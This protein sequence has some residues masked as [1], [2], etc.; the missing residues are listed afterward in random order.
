MTAATWQHAPLTWD[1][2]SDVVVVGSGFAG[3]AAA[4]EAR[5]AGCSVVV[6]EKM[7]GYGGNSL[8][9]AGFVAAAGT[10]LQKKSGIPDSAQLMFN[11]MLKSGL[12]LN[13]PELVRTLTEQSAEML[14]WTID[15][16]GV[17]Y[18][19][20]IDQYGGHSV[21]RSYLPHNLS[22][23][24]I[25]KPLLSKVASMGVP[26]RTCHFVQQLCK[27]EDRRVCGVRVLKGY[28]FPAGDSGRLISIKANKGVVLAAGGFGADT[29]FR[30][31]QNP[32]FN[33]TVESTNKYSTTADSLKQALH[34]GAMPVQLSWIQLAPWTTPDEKA[35][36]IGADFAEI[37][38]SPYG[39]LV[40]PATGQRFISE[41]ADRRLQ[42]DAIINIGH[43]CIGIVDEKGAMASGIDYTRCVKRGIVKTFFNIKAIA[44]NYRM[45]V[46][47]LTDTIRAF[48]RFIVRGKGD[49]LGKPML[50]KAR[51]IEHPPYYGIRLWPK[52]HYTMGGILINTKA[53]VMDLNRQ[54][55]A[56]FYA[57]GEITGGIHGACR[58]ATC[59]ITDCLVYG[60]IAGKNAAANS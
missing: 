54:P 49:L 13:H 21:P 60:R 59:A 51:P 23:S 24:G 52:V 2:E 40:N 41:L 18:V 20:R 10:A 1:E 7:K 55:I 34:I 50:S 27:D 3:L 19:D 48:N 22:G 39:V 53:Q 47:A 58:L 30:S 11:D 12:G 57:A 44:E 25:V 8:L 35:Y 31:L 42:A 29:A 9:S 14:D 17:R 4:I 33:Q 32:R 38:V 36:G 5:N 15:V 56:G 16:V 37:A 6:L 45:P 46:D 26:I 28:R 43:P